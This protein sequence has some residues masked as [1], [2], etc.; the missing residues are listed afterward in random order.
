[1]LMHINKKKSINLFKNLNYWVGMVAKALV[2][3]TDDN[4]NLILGTHMGKKKT[5]SGKSSSDLHTFIH[6]HMHAHTTTTTTL[7]ISEY[8]VLM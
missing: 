2:A 4:L 3:R 7:Y 8:C 5:S 1:M 6:T